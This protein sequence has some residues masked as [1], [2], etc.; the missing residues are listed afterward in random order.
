MPLDTMGYDFA[1]IYILSVPFS[2]VWQW[3]A[4]SN[5]QLDISDVPDGYFLLKMIKANRLWP[6]QLIVN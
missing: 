3:S 5:L 4:T 6:K 1:N 2:L